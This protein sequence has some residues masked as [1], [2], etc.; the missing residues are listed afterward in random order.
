MAFLER[1][2]WSY[3]VFVDV[4]HARACVLSWTQVPNV[5]L[6]REEDIVATT[7][8]S[9][10][11]RLEEQWARS[12]VTFSRE[13]KKGRA[14]DERSE[15]KKRDG[16]EVYGNELR[17]KEILLVSAD[18]GKKAFV[19]IRGKNARGCSMSVD[20]CLFLSP[21]LWSRRLKLYRNGSKC[22]KSR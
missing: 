10:Y 16:G 2:L 17:E 7:P 5:K 4:V 12:P 9:I 15:R 13:R 18:R 14:G 22:E 21:F 19:S 1:R 6:S 20:F 8:L 11:T 3:F